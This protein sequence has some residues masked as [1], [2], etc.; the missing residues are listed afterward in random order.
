MNFFNY[1]VK[2]EEA[3]PQ[4]DPQPQEKVDPRM[5]IIDGAN[6]IKL[7]ADNPEI[8]EGKV[9]IGVSDIGYWQPANYNPQTGEM[10]G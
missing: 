7:V 10:V 9:D 5:V 6:L 4:P 2:E 3:T 1:S 8:P